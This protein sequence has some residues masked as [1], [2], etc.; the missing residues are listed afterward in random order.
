MRL[1]RTIKT[2]MRRAVRPSEW[3]FRTHIGWHLGIFSAV[4]L[5]GVV[6]VLSFTRNLTPNANSMNAMLL[7][8]SDSDGND[9][10]THLGSVAAES[11][12]LSQSLSADIQDRIAEYGLSFDDLR[13]QPGY[14]EDIL[15]RETDLLMLALERANCSGV[16]VALDATLNP[17]L[18]GAENSR[19]GVYIRRVE[20]KRIGNPSEMLYLRGFTQFAQKRGMTL[21]ANWDLEFDI[22]GRDFWSLP[23]A[24]SAE[25]PGAPLVNLYVWSLGAIT[26]E[27]K[28]PALLCSL[29][30]LDADGNAIGVCGLEMSQTGFRYLLPVPT[31]PYRETA[32]LFAALDAGGSDLDMSKK[33]FSGSYKI[34][35]D[36]A[37]TAALPLQ[38]TGGKL[39]VFH[40][41]SFSFRG[42]QKEISLYP[43]GSLFAGHR[44][45]LTHLISEAAYS[46]EIRD[47]ILR[48]AAIIAGMLLL[49][50][51]LTI[52]LSARLAA[53]VDTALQ[54]MRSGDPMEPT[55]TVGIRELDELLR[56]FA[57]RN[58]GQTAQIETMFVGFL[59][60]LESLTP[61]ERAITAHYAAGK[62]MEEVRVEMVIAASTLKTHNV[63]IYKK[64][65]INSVDELRL[66]LT[67]LKRSNSGKTLSDF[68]Q[69]R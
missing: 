23:L 41:D 59:D 51:I 69:T 16:F 33:L 2:G 34:E 62:S 20:P 67:L 58:P 6:L 13:D 55:L 27:T 8:L 46:K 5:L 7:R 4:M 36:L 45:A 22:A 12:V 15:D 38:D 65:D 52:F 14:L 11:V 63:H 31:E 50:F 17:S 18:P 9:L 43:D 42:V 40:T 19:A 35:T 57:D 30:L 48:G 61:T 10:K 25:A 29:P 49:G 53:P 54:T 68:L 28:D 26:P 64:L 47:D 21:Q 39:G 37:H 24:A 56:L 44:F 60:K 66:Y 32:L 3:N 1:W